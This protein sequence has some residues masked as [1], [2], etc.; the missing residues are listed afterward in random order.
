MSRF[1]SG[2]YVSG[3][4]P[5]TPLILASK[6]NGTL[7]IGFTD[8]LVRRV[9]EHRE[10]LIPEFTSRYGIKMLVWYETFD[11]RDDAFRRERQMKVWR[12]AWKIELIEKANPGWRDLYPELC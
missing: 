11:T 10:G 7:Y 6:R 12:R 5:K 2:V 4:S 1:V 8:S 3:V 9:G